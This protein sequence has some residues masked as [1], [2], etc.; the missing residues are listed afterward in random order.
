MFIGMMAVRRVLLGLLGPM[1]WPWRAA[2]GQ[3]PPSQGARLGAG[4]TVTYFVATESLDAR[5]RAG[6]RGLAVAALE[7]WGRLVSPPLDLVP[8]AEE[9]ATVRLYWVP[10]GFGLY[11]EMR[12]REVDGRPAADVFVHPDTDALGPD[13]A[14]AAREDPLFRDAIVYL[15]CVHEL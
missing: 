11:G 1:L 5:S 9:S 12:A 4:R 10:A 13:I 8:A 14:R 15:T 7:A 3:E 2:C 6:D